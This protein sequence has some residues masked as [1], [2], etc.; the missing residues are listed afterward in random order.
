MIFALIPLL[1]TGCAAYG[2]N[3][4]PPLPADVLTCFTKT[5]KAPPKGSMD[6]QQIIKLI[7][8]LRRSELAKSACGQR[9]I[10]FYTIL[11]K[12]KK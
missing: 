2:T 6:Q 1:L 11:E 10:S 12:G 9:L 3:S 4:L 5:A 8:Q 7:I